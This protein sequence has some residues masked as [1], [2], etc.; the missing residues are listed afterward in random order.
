MTSECGDDTTQRSTTVVAD[1]AS[2]ALVGLGATH[3]K[4]A[5]KN[6]ADV[7]AWFYNSLCAVNFFR[8]NRASAQDC[9]ALS[10]SRDIQKKFLE[11]LTNRVL[12]LESDSPNAYDAKLDDDWL[13]AFIEY[14]EK[15]VKEPTAVTAKTTKLE[16]SEKRRE[17]TA[18]VGRKMEVSKV[19]Q[20][21]SRL[22][23][24]LTKE[25]RLK[26]RR[27]KL[28]EE[29]L[30]SS[31]TSELLVMLSPIT[32]DVELEALVDAILRYDTTSHE[33]TDEVTLPATHD[34]DSVE[35]AGA[36]FICV[37]FYNVIEWLCK[38]PSTLCVMHA[39]YLQS[40]LFIALIG[41]R[42]FVFASIYDGCCC[43]AADR[44]ESPCES[45]TFE[46][47]EEDSS[48]A[49]DHDDDAADHI[50]PHRKSTR[51]TSLPMSSDVTPS[52]E[53]ALELRETLAYLLT[54]LA[55]ELISRR[56]FSAAT[57]L[58]QRALSM[59]PQDA[60]IATPAAGSIFKQL[61]MLK[62]LQGEVMHGCQLLVESARLFRGAETPCPLMLATVLCDL[63]GAMLHEYD[64]VTSLLAHVVCEVR[65]SLDDEM[66]V[67]SLTDSDVTQ[68]MTAAREAMEHLEDCLG[69]LDA[70]TE[71]ER[72]RE[73][74]T[75]L[76][77]ALAKMGDCHV[78]A[79]ELALAA[80]YYEQVLAV[81]KKFVGASTLDKN[82]HVMSMLGIVT[83][84]LGS[85]S[86]AI[87]SLQTA[88]VLQ[89]HLSTGTCSFESDFTLLMLA[90]A[91]QRIRK[92]HRSVVWCLLALDGEAKLEAELDAN[93]SWLVAQTIITLGHAYLETDMLAKASICLELGENQFKKL[94]NVDPKQ[95]IQL[96]KVSLFS[97]WKYMTFVDHATFYCFS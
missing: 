6:R 60:A 9:V 32:D 20:A 38:L 18:E 11:N 45:L 15:K 79:G 90:T 2:R 59:L 31:V 72:G 30:R 25:V 92:P 43:F 77:S 51:P 7:M 52:L 47:I 69:S 19:V 5:H 81:S 40:I 33:V 80:E 39:Y 26:Y 53:S 75:L 96:L 85:H 71:S 13:N 84:L 83:Y 44:I 35:L 78:I 63:A 64:P 1:T 62:C 58:F 73:F 54:E 48:S 27:R 42:V 76:V 55:T 10:L 94:T 86:K 22:V 21:L 41:S 93:H 89:R 61:G 97:V 36:K 12:V 14:M 65:R 67:A 74:G 66:P 37:C 29:M 56:H 87:N 70:V 8:Q 4:I 3:V 88:V 34:D 24:W 82:A 57:H 95:L 68:E 46:N 17:K 23:E 16:T 28:S 49:D 91:F 50:N